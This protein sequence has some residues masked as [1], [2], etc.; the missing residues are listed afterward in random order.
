[1]AITLNGVTLPP[2]LR[3]TNEFSSSNVTQNVKYALDGSPVVFFGNRSSGNPIT[4]ESSPDQGWAT[5]ETVQSIAV[6]AA[7]PGAVLTLSIRGESRQVMFSHQS[8]PAFTATPV[9]H[10]AD[11]VLGDWY[12]VKLNL[13]TVY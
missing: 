10:K 13:M 5:L 2:G 9:V 1:M 7:N 11:P 8:P 4:L 12:T 6:M 3:W